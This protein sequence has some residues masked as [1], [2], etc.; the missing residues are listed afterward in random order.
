MID[1]PAYIP[2]D[3]CGLTA[4]VCQHEESVENKIREAALEVGVDPDVAWAIAFC[5]SHGI[6]TASNPNSSAL[7]LF[8]ILDMHNLSKE[9]RL[10]A[11]CNIDWAINE[12]KLHGFGAWNASRA[13][14]S[15]SLE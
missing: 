7:G 5:E 10:N 4:V 13:C 2:P 3:L 1:E 12:M 14:W 6:E 15:K 9:C 8:Q 11:D